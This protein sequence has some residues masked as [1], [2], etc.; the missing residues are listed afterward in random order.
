MNSKRHRLCLQGLSLV[1]PLAF[2]QAAAGEVIWDRAEVVI[3]HGKANAISEEFDKPIPDGE[4]KTLKVR[5]KTGDNVLLLRDMTAATDPNSELIAVIKDSTAATVTV[6][7]KADA[8]ARQQPY[9]VAVS[10]E[11]QPG[12]GGP[13]AGGSGQTAWIDW[14][15]A[16]ETH[17]IATVL[18]ALKVEEVG[19]EAN[20]IV[21]DE[22]PEGKLY[23]IASGSPDVRLEPT[24]D[25]DEPGGADSILWL[26]EREDTEIDSGDF[27][28]TPQPT[29]ALHVQDEERAFNVFAGSDH[30]SDGT[31]DVGSGSDEDQFH[32]LVTVV[33]VNGITL[34]GNANGTFQAGEDRYVF[35]QLGRLS[36]QFIADMEPEASASLEV[37]LRDSFKWTLDDNPAG[38]PDEKI[39]PYR[40]HDDEASAIGPGT[41]ID[42]RKF[43][44]DQLPP[45]NAGFGEQ[46]LTLEVT[47]PPGEDDPQ[48]AKN[49]KPRLFYE[50]TH[51]TH[52]NQPTEKTPNWYYY[53]AQE[54]EPGVCDYSRDPN[55][56]NYAAYE[57]ENPDADWAFGTY[58]NG[59]IYLHDPAGATDSWNFEFPEVSNAT[60]QNWVHV[61][62]SIDN[63]P[64][65]VNLVL[66]HERVHKALDG[67]GMLDDDDDNVPDDWEDDIPG[68][69]TDETDSFGEHFDISEGSDASRDEEFYCV[70]GGAFTFGS[71]K[72]SGATN[73]DD[74]SV[75]LYRANEGVPQSAD[76]ENDWSKDGAN[77]E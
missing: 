77:W 55:A 46:T 48:I 51:K 44:I 25:E 72:E 35:H 22:K 47:H 39:D 21:L 65:F 62:I 2:A 53:W 49:A 57:S 27:G 36:L 18:E 5:G 14:E 17:V 4:S 41:A 37:D 59:T 6:G 12:G 32:A 50:R 75:N 67:H 3:H 52:P 71:I 20:H 28:S 11:Y 60:T 16:P 73:A 74:L 15:A 76:T 64:D 1:L 70:I 40:P 10:G 29:I 34:Y 19:H 26:V 69:K 43:T 54:G 66:A 61:E 13:G 8:Q 42:R 31:L 45:T 68:M 24:I 30:D 33:K 63:A 58:S 23:V 38:I 56:P 9:P 7:T